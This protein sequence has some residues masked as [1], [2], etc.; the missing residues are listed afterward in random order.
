MVYTLTQQPMENICE[1]IQNKNSLIEIG[2]PRFELCQNLHL[3]YMVTHIFVLLNVAI[4]LVIVKILD[5]QPI[6]FVSKLSTSI[7]MKD[8]SKYLLSLKHIG[9]RDIFGLLHVNPVP[10]TDSSQA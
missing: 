5:V 8:N 1:K 10:G 7:I 3:S 4:I 6:N 9:D 2:A